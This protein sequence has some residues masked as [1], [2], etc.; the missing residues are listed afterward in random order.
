ME[1][2]PLDSPLTLF[3]TAADCRKNV[4]TRGWQRSASSAQKVRPRRASAAGMEHGA[5]G[6]AGSPLLRGHH[7]ALLQ[8]CLGP[9]ALPGIAGLE[10]SWQAQLFPCCFSP[11]PAKVMQANV[12]WEA[13]V[14]LITVPTV[15]VPWKPSSISTMQAVCVWTLAL[16]LRAF[17]PG[18]RAQN[19]W[20]PSGELLGLSQ[21]IGKQGMEGNVK[22]APSFGESWSLRCEVL[23]RRRPVRRGLCEGSPEFPARSA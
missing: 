12:S 5:P 20:E 15:N 2:H 7:A 22:K 14:H 13:C 9:P 19:L 1:L 17:G 21:K 11:P 16:L 6:Q 18:A 3:Q 4:T 8:A 10:A 23:Q